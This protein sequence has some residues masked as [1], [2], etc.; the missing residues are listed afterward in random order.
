MG[1]VYLRKCDVSFYDHL[2]F[3]RDGY[4]G[5]TPRSEPEATVT[6]ELECDRDTAYKL[7]EA[8]RSQYGGQRGVHY[9]HVINDDPLFDRGPQHQQIEQKQTTPLPAEPAVPQL[10][11]ATFEEKD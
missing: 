2:S 7:A 10:P 6:L 3:R 5:K 1:Y 11:G 4:L 9:D 8:F